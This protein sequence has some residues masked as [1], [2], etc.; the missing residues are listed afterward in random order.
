M[1]IQTVSAVQCNTHTPLSCSGRC[2]IFNVQTNNYSE[3][4]CVEKNQ[5]RPS[6]WVFNTTAVAGHVSSGELFCVPESY[7]NVTRNSLLFF[8]FFL[9]V[10]IPTR[11][12]LRICA[13]TLLCYR[14][15]VF[16]IRGSN[17][18]EFEGP[19][20]LYPLKNRFL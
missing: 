16:T 4:L 12:I 3:F 11:I 20:S 7:N 6:T 9:L 15:W 5:I 17:G 8:F 18:G 14:K 2:E 10:Y 19:R 13:V 1:L